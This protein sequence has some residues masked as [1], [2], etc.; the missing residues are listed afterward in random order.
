MGLWGVSESLFPSISL[1][2]VREITYDFA[3]DLEI[4]N[5]SNIKMSQRYSRFDLLGSLGKCFRS[6]I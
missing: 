5:V 1:F 2:H 4:P 6:E 3:A